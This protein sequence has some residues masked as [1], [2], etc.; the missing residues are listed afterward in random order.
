VTENNRIQLTGVLATPDGE[1]FLK[2]TE[3]GPLSDGAGIGER[4][5]KR[6]LEA[7]GREILAT[8]G[9]EAD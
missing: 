1:Q 7:G 5:G 9:I 3:S 6:L 8:V 2:M 4:L